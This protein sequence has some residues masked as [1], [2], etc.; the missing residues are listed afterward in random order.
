MK[1]RI[2]A[3]VLTVLAGGAA[4]AA[5]AGTATA[6]PVAARPAAN[7]FVAQ[8]I[9]EVA[10][11]RLAPQTPAGT[12]FVTFRLTRPLPG[13]GAE[14]YTGRVRISGIGASA[15]DRADFS[16]PRT[17]CY[18]AAAFPE[19]FGGRIGHRVRVTFTGL[20]GLPTTSARLVTRRLT[21]PDGATKRLG[22][23]SRHL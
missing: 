15:I 7:H 4:A 1:K 2:T 17:R 18:S 3:T 6:A 14:P 12:G 21:S 8:A 9:V 11:R 20:P 10:P 16:R 22:C 13:G 5:G 23:A 19:R